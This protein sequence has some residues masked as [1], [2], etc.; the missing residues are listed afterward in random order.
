MARAFRSSATKL[1]GQAFMPS[2][3]MLAEHVT[4]ACAAKLRCELSTSSPALAAKRILDDD[5]RGVFRYASEKEK[6]TP[7]MYVWGYAKTG[8]L[9]VR[10]FVKPERGAVAKVRDVQTKPYRLKFADHYPIRDVA[11]GYGFTVYIPKGR[12]D[13]YMLLG[14]GLNVD[15]QLGYHETRK[16]SGVSLGLVAQPVPIHLPVI[17]QNTKVVNV[18]CGRAHTVVL[19]DQEGVMS[20][21]NNA[22]GQCGRSV[23]KDEKYSSNRI[24]S[25]VK[26]LP[27]NVS[28]VV[29][30]K[31][32]TFFLTGDGQVYSCG[33]SSCGQSD[34][35]IPTLIK[36]DIEGEKIVQLS[37]NGGSVLALSDSGEIYG[38]GS[39][40]YYQLSSVTEEIQ[41]NVPRHLP[42]HRCGKAIQVAVTETVCAFL[43]TDGHVYVWGCGILGLGPENNLVKQPTRIPE[44]L[45]GHN[46]LNPDSRVVQLASGH[47][48]FAGI[49]DNGDL[50]TWGYNSMAS[51]GLGHK[52]DQYFPIKVIIAAEVKKVVCG[53]DHMVAMAKSVT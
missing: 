32:S 5:D 19:T 12:S 13:D 37:S 20:L 24:I 36:G 2:K 43:N 10:T 26:G 34:V 45:F 6:R 4:A 8:A 15:S 51:L 30:G 9:G 14:T 53:A 28:S 23:V 50:Y 16:G 25:K 33:I 39:S 38:W 3:P 17:H 52:K 35:S 11:C 31:D 42:I 21:G 29:C 49:K 44:V 40:E 27:S 18:A 48:H 46:E 47:G 22:F 1:K 41:V 7:R